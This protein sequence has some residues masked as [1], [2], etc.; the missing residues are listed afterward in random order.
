M[1]SKLLRAIQERSVRP[2]GSTQEDAVDVRIV[3]AT[4]RD[5]SADVKN[6][7]FR[8]DLYYRLNVIEIVVPP[9]RERRED[10]SALCQALLARIALESGMPV[11]PLSTALLQELQAHPLAGNVRELENLLHRAVAMSEG[12]ELHA[13]FPATQNMGLPD[14]SMHGAL[15]DPEGATPTDLQAYLDQQERDILVRVLQETG[16]NRT[17]TAARLG[18]SLRQIRYRIARLNIATPQDNEIHEE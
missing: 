9:L 17:A 16:F 2:L 3:S 4:H 8:Q 5:L 14:H 1:Q 7:R 12:D 18:L 6:G 15:R 10:L 11:P 13:E